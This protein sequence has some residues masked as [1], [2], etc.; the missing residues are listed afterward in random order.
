[1]T[2]AKGTTISDVQLRQVEGIWFCVACQS[3]YCPH[4]ASIAASVHERMPR[5]DPGRGVFEGRLP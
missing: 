5:I 1:M 3:S 2:L 4:L